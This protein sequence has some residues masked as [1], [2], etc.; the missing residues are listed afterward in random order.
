MTRLVALHDLGIALALDDFGTGFSS[1]S[2]LHRFPIQILK[3]DRSF[4]SGMNDSNVRASGTT[5]VNAIVSMAQS[6]GLDLVAE[7]I[8]NESQRRL[9]CSL[10]CTYG[11]G[12]HLGRPVPADA[13]DELINAAPPT[14]DQSSA[15]LRAG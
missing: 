9:L 7:G 14:N 13:I 5:V 6:L 8:E 12:F 2:Y 1:L 3:I 4:V 11:Q 10:G 15:S